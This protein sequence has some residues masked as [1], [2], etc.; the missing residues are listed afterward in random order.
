M[1]GV[2]MTQEE[3]R[4]LYKSRLEKEKQTYISKA[5]EIDG[6]LLSKFKNGKIDLYPHLFNRLEAYLLNN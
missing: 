5:V 2:Y 6:S 3:L 4:E 1:K